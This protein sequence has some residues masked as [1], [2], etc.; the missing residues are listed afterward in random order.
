MCANL[1]ASELDENERMAS[2]GIAKYVLDVAKRSHKF[3]LFRNF[4]QYSLKKIQ[5]KI[6]LKQRARKT[7]WAGRGAVR[8]KNVVKRSW[9]VLYLFKNVHQYSLTIKFQL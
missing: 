2:Q 6:Q 8:M 1:C 9:Q 5:E 4:H 3:Y 7:K